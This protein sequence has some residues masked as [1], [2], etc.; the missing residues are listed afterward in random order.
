MA[1]IIVCVIGIFPEDTCICCLNRKT[2]SYSQLAV[3][4]QL[5]LNISVLKYYANFT[6]KHPCWS[7]YYK[8]TPGQMFS[9][10]ICENFNSNFFYRTA[11]VAASKLGLKR[12]KFGKT[13]A[14]IKVAYKIKPSLKFFRF[15]D[16][17]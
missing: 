3:K 14:Y 12:K 13:F 7:L 16:L 15:V 10:E 6:G 2:N 9:C 8:E 5:F 4:V 11:P 1:R 17:P